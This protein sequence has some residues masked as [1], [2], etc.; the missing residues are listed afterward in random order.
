MHTQ[1][2]SSMTLAL[3]LSAGVL[4]TAPAAPALA[5]SGQPAASADTAGAHAHRR[6]GRFKA[7]PEERAVLADL[8]ALTRVYLQSNRASELPALYRSVL[9]KTDNETIRKVANRMLERAGQAPQNPDQEIAR[10]TRQ[11]NDGLAG[12]PAGG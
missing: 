11:L 6:H 8:H 2:F 7:T 10:L 5:Q 12:L 4:L 1:T 3:A 9:A